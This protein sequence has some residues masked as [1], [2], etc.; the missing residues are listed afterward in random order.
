MISKNVHKFALF[1][2]G[3]AIYNRLEKSFRSDAEITY[4]SSTAVDSFYTLRVDKKQTFFDPLPSYLVHV[5]IEW[6]YS[7]KERQEELIIGL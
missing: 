2:V 4:L 6:P 7:T 3:I 1:S 5:V